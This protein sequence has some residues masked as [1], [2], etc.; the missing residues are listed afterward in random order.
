LSPRLH[1]AFVAPQLQKLRPLAFTYFVHF[2]NLLLRSSCGQAISLVTIAQMTS[3]CASFVWRKDS[4][5]SSGTYG[6]LYDELSRPEIRL[7]T[8]EYQQ[9]PL[10]MLIRNETRNGLQSD[11]TQV[12]HPRTNHPL[13]SF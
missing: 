11:V 3:R 5:S 2:V 13:P 10:T 1:F 6:T 12:D 9:L 4:P 8:S 7:T